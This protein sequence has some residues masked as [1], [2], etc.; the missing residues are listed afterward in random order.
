MQDQSA[1]VNAEFSSN[2][3]VNYSG[4]TPEAQT[5]FQ[6]AV[7]IWASLL[8]SDVDII[9]DASFTDLGSGVLGSAGASFQVRDFKNAPSDTVFYPIALAEKLAGEELNLPG[10]SEITCRFNSD[11]D[12]YFG[13]DGNPPSSQHDFVTIVLHE[14]GHGLGFAGA[15]SMD[16]SSG[17]WDYFNFKTNRYNEFVELGNGTPIIDLP[18]GGSQTGNALT[19]DNLYFNGPLSAALPTVGEGSYDDARPKLYAP[20]NY[21][22]GSS[23]SHVDESSYTAGDPHSLMTP[24]LGEGESIFDP[25]VALDI[26]ADMGWFITI[27]D[28]DV[29]KRLVDNT[30][31]DI[32][33]EVTLRTDT[34]VT[35]T[36]RVVYST[37]DF[38]SESTITLTEGSPGVWSTTITNPGEGILKYY[39]DNVSDGLGRSVRS[40]MVDGNYFEVEIK[41]IA[42]ETLS[43]GSNLYDFES[44][45]QGFF[46]LLLEGNT[47]FWERGAPGNVL[48]SSSSSTN[49]WKTGLTTDVGDAGV[50]IKEALVSP[51]FDMADLNANYLL[52][53]E[54][55]MDIGEIDGEPYDSGPIGANVEYTIDRGVTW[56]TLGVENDQAGDEWY[57]FEITGGGYFSTNVFDNEAGWIIDSVN[58][59]VPVSYN[60]SRLAGN[61]Y[62]GF[63]IVFYAEADFTDEG[64]LADGVLVD[65][66]E[67]EKG[68]PT[69]DFVV[70]NPSPLFFPGGTVNF[71]YISSGATTYSWD[72]GDGS[73]ASTEKNPSH[74]YSS[75]GL[76]T[77]TLTIDGGADVVTKEDLITVISEEGSNYLLSDGGNFE[78]D[79]GD[80]IAAN[81]SGTGFE[82]GE[83]SIEGK[84]GTVSGDF[85][86]VTG[87]TDEEYVD[88]SEAFLY[89]PL[90]DF[91]YLGTYELSFK[92]NYNT[93]EGWDGFIVEYS[94]DF[95]ETWEQLNP[96]VAE[97]W[98][99]LIGEDNPAQGW[100]AIPLFTGN[101]GGDYVT[102][103]ADISS[104]GG[105][106]KIAFRFHWL[107]DFASTLVG[108]AIDNFKLTGPV[109]GTAVPQFSFANATG[110]DGQVV[111]FSNE[112]TGSVT[113]IE[114]DFGANASP[115][116][117]SGHGP[118]EVTYS[119]SGSSTVTLTI[120]DDIGGD[121]VEQKVNII[122][123]SA[124]HEPVIT[125]EFKSSIPGYLLT[126]SSGD[127]YQW[128]RDGEILN[129]ETSQTLEVDVGDGG[130]FTALVTVGS[131]EVEAEGV[132]VNNV[133]ED[134][135][136]IFPNPTSD[137]IQIESAQ[138]MSGTFRIYNTNGRLIKIGDL[139]GSP[140]DVTSFNDGLYIL[141]VEMDQQI[142]NKSIVI[143]K[144][145]K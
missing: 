94:S 81:I 89:T 129:G 53:F 134:V 144:S 128:L 111:T 37:N 105:E 55:G 125:S 29:D 65:N 140:I 123:T 106:G 32:P 113:A 83:S 120:S 17:N 31:D 57:N 95:G 126:A 117:A 130:N 6:F 72:F 52:K 22:G 138:P 79:N 33:I 14:L 58:A 91:T 93:E 62:V 49:V 73:P 78:V 19:G 132:I 20:S 10:E 82:R 38:V 127:A 5:A 145:K 119:G 116:V 7:D 48:T 122:E 51:Y 44:G 124:L 39:F 141:K 27:L 70:A 115:A 114:W 60:I 142:L 3:I 35:G 23:F 43:A 96:E 12:F 21:S 102:K 85:A 86:W 42:Q 139:D 136:N 90:F 71:E 107:S 11:F 97:G 100:P 118:H 103:S 46:P 1:R 135:L 87:L 9:V 131:C 54:L 15:S 25:G 68:E 28:H 36:P 45:A 75:G 104:L 69:A 112:S 101:T 133:L 61:D 56:Q 2:I 30:T 76:Y 18:T 50:A 34:T 84:D 4:F 109:P 88:Q 41:N 40:P 67:I 110:C 47:G 99:D 8:P 26:F 137:Y 16:G 66:F 24:Q 92:A 143:N 59:A 80:F 77:V 64:Y 121:F 74:T 13:T 63:R 108:I 98:Y